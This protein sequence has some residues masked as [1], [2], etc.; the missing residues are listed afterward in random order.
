MSP[1]DRRPG[2]R[3]RH[4]LLPEVVEEVC[5]GGRARVAAEMGWEF[6]RHPLYELSVGERRVAVF[7]PRHR[8]PDGRH[9]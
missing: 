3:R 1:T 7:H 5:G 6:P 8:G 4:L 2:P 9:R